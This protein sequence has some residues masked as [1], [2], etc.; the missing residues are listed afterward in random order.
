[1]VEGKYVSEDDLRKKLF[2]DYLKETLD[3]KE[4]KK[5]CTLERKSM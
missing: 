5:I 1:M 3:R 2:Q 4:S